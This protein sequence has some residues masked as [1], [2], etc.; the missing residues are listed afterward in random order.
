MYQHS[1]VR[2]QK[3]ETMYCNIKRIITNAV[4]LLLTNIFYI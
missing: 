4:G 1:Q 3:D 2:E